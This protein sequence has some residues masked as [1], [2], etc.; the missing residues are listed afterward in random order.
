MVFRYVFKWC[1]LRLGFCDWDAALK[2]KKL[3]TLFLLTVLCLGSRFSFAQAQPIYT[4]PVSKIGGAMAEGITQTLIRRGFAANDPRIAQT[5][6]AVGA[7]VAAAGGGNWL[8][9]FGRLSPWVTGGLL[10]W[11]GIQWWLDSQGNVTI[12]QVV[13]IPGSLGGAIVVGQ[14]FYYAESGCAGGHPTLEDVYLEYSKCALGAEKVVQ[15][16]IDQVA[17]STTRWTENAYYTY[18]G[19][20]S[21]RSQYYGIYVSSAVASISCPAGSHIVSGTCVA[22]QHSKDTYQPRS[23]PGVVT[24][25]QAAYDALPQA[26][27]EAAISPAILAELT[28]RAWRDGSSA[29]DW[30]AVPFSANDPVSNSDF[31]PLQSAHPADY[32]STSELNSPIPANNPV[33]SSNSNP[34]AV[35]SP[36]NSTKIDLGTDPGTPAPV[37]DEPPTDLFKPISDLLQPWLNWKV[38][39]HSSQCPT[40]QASPAI[41]GHV[42]LI[43]LSFHCTLIEQYRQLLSSAAAIAWIV[44]AAFIVL[45]A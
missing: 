32:P 34:N 4:Q 16:F 5:I 3:L 10:V 39:E 7:R 23:I 14:T 24:T 28:N 36:A 26:A 13:A 27:K 1:L 31:G 42:F 22:N 44:V 17:G 35:S 40:W 20:D 38:P 37:L 41:A 12:Q 25:P 2:M 9:L 45:S 29:A 19:S 33:S 15:L 43:D 21:E 8:S 18:P 6:T 30:P 11:Q